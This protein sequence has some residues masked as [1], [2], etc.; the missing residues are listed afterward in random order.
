MTN[1]GLTE[2]V[3]IKLGK[4]IAFSLKKMKEMQIIHRDIKCENILLRNGNAK[5]GDFGFA[6]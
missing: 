5:L 6:I 1:N 4:Q 2:D 3:A